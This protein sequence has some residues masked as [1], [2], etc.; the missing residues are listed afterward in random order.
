MKKSPYLLYALLLMS[1]SGYGQDTI[2]RNWSLNGYATNMQSF[3]FTRFN[4]DWTSD[5]L[6]HNRINFNWHNTANTLVVI[7][8]VRNRLMTGESIETIPG[9]DNMVDI[10]NG[11]VDLSGNVLSGESC[12]LNSKIDRAYLDFT[13]NKFQVRVGR[14]RINWGQCFTWNPNDLFNTYSFFDFDYVE[15]PG[16]DAVRLQYFANTTS[17]IEM[18]AKADL[19]QRITTAALYRFNRWNYDFQVMVG[20][21]NQNDYVVG[22]GWSGNIIDASFRGEISYFQPCQQ[23]ADTS[24]VMVVSLGSEYVFKNA[25]LLQCEVL[26]NQSSRHEISDFTDY[27]SMDLSA[28]NLSFSEF[29]L[30]VQGSYPVTPLLNA[31]LTCM[32]FP[33]LKGVFIGPTLTQSL[34]DN[35][36]F[37]LITQS[38]A[39]QANYFHF[40]FMRLKWSF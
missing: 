34:T 1:I 38:F 8:E 9:Y 20:V 4:G 23:W 30:M 24:G 5:N 32:Y 36:D 40:A 31:S 26:Y 27:Y 13:Q 35:I 14:Q 17:A 15:K 2:P 16:S 25:L 12:V 28:K 29:S 33:N 6:I 18:A 3:T 39:R 21:L 22:G 10:D 37:S 19:N 7:T 11:Y